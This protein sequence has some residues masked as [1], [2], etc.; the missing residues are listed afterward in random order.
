MIQLIKINKTKTIL[1]VCDECDAT[2]LEGEEISLET[3]RDLETYME[4]TLGVLYT[5]SEITIIS[6]VLD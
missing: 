6:K 2:W 4:E 1:Q 5:E 3:F